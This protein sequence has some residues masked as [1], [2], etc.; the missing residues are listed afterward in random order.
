MSGGRYNSSNVANIRAFGD[1]D[2]DDLRAALDYLVKLP[3][4][5]RSRVVVGGQSGGGLAT[6][7]FGFQPNIEVRG[8]LNFAGGLRSTNDSWRSLMVQAFGQ[9]GAR[10]KAPSLWFYAANDS[11]F[12]HEQAQRAYD[13]YRSSGGDRAQLVKVDAF[14]N[15]GHYLFSDPDGVSI[16]WPPTEKFLRQIGVLQ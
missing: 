2:A 7:A 11:F 4:V 5:D 14:K 13:A 1:Y 16:W 6:L 8:L 9:Y 3:Q 10:T 12:D 15:D